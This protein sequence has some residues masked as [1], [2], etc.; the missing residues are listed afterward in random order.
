[1][2]IDTTLT[3]TTK[4]KFSVQI[5]RP[6]YSE[7]GCGVEWRDESSY[8]E[9]EDAEWKSKYL[10]LI[11]GQLSRVIEIETKTTVPEIA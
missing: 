1:M 5:G 9:K 2:K 3:T 7:Y 6:W 10:R 4:I 8:A 11:K